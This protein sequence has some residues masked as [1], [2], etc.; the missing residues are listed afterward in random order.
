MKKA[1]TLLALILTSS[2]SFAQETVEPAGSPAT[3]FAGSADG[4]YKYDF[5]HVTNGYTS[6]TNTDNSFELGMVSLE[7][8]H[9]WKKASVFV[10]LGFGSRAKEFTYND[11][12]YSFMIKQLTFTYDVSDS[13]KFVAGTFGTHVGYELLDAVDN[14]NYSMS[15]AFTYGPF[16]NTG[17]KAQYTTGKLSF[18]AGVTNPTDF[19]SALETGTDAKTFI[20]QIAY[21]GETGSAYLNLSTG[22]SNGAPRRDIND[23]LLPSDED[24][25]QF[26]FVATKKFGDKF[27]LGFNATYANTS[28][29]IDGDL[30]GDWFS[31]VLYPTYSISSNVLLAYRLEYLDSED[32]AASMG[33]LAG[34][35]VI[36]NT[37]SLNYK[38]GNMTIIP[39]FRIDS[40]SNDIFVANDGAF[41]GVNTYALV[42]ATYTF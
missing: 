27:A 14:K 11:N 18:M 37:L 33:A 20:G 41:K 13:F 25:T 42:A 28:N 7:A 23:D 22:A 9:K 3:V 5:S 38:V 12:P 36:G 2:I 31:L 21:V 24:K 35:S 19:K 26:D 40:A 17:I 4:Y 15:Y 30:D 10:D 6:F 32:A 1:V 29:N 8:S 34:S 39:E 16:Y